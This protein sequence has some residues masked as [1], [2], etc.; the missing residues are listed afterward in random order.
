MEYSCEKRNQLQVRD[1]VSPTLWRKLV[2]YG[3]WLLL[4]ICS[5]LLNLCYSNLRAYR[6]PWPFFSRW[7]AILA[8]FLG[9]ELMF[10]KY[11]FNAY[12]RTCFVQR[13]VI[14]LIEM[15]SSGFTAE[16]TSL[17]PSATEKD[18]HDFFS[19]CGAVQHVEIIRY[20]Q[21]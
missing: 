1:Y 20:N 5:E 3:S 12:V 10:W 6:V 18:V 2:L 9:G 16:V 21:T 11:A 7:R 4:N 15:S 8:S 13:G 14:T 19:F 17:S